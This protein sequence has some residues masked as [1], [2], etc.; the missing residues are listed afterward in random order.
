M[1]EKSVPALIWEAI[2]ASDLVKASRLFAENPAEIDAYTFFGGGTYL[3][4]AAEKGSPAMIQLLVEL[5]FDV[6]KPGKLWGDVALC[7]A[8]GTGRPEN[9]GCLLGLGSVLDVSA[10][11][12]N[13]LFSC[14]SGFTS[15]RDV[16]PEAFM[17]CAQLLLEAG[18][19]ASVVYD[20]D[21]MVEMDAIAFATMWGRL[22]IA[23]QI[24][25]HIHGDDEQRVRSALEEA[26]VIADGNA[27]N[28]KAF[29][30]IRRS[31]K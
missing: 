10:S 16:A 6:N 18:L 17:T 21:T 26:A 29:R 5:G 4:Y 12:R 1:V 22:D 14:I 28:L 27:G 2:H 8:C 20:T 23:D 30:R 13:P 3:H 7:G 24:A 15:H 9:V 19:D 11:I 31:R 25:A